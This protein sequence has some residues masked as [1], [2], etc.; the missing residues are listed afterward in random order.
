MVSVFLWLP[1]R[2]Y[3]LNLKSLYSLS[4]YL[5][6]DLYTSLELICTMSIWRC[7]RILWHGGGL[8]QLSYVR[9]ESR[10]SDH[11]PVFSVF[12]AE[13]ESE[14]SRLRKMRRSSSRIE[15]EELLPYS[16][17]YTEL[18]FFW[19]RSE[20]IKPQCLVCSPF[21]SRYTLSFG[22]FIYVNLVSVYDLYGMLY[23]R[24]TILS[25]L[26]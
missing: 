8:Q 23:L 1:K 19:S 20:D 13:V 17:G 15:V 21:L 16:H 3:I 18:C 5:V 11:R 2:T 9:G 14:R 10:F 25:H 4:K 24:N 6:E 12:L 7:D 22:F 26:N